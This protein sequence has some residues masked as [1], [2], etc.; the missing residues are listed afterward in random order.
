VQPV[1][2]SLALLWYV[3]FVLSTTA[4]EASH[5]LAALLGGDPT[6]YHGGQVSL[7]PVPHM[8]REPFGMVILPL[9]FAVSSGWCVGWASTPY[10]PRWEARFPRRAAWMAAAGPAANLAIAA[11]ALILL[12]AGLASGM[13]YAPDSVSLSQ[14]VAGAT[15]AVHALGAFLSILLFLNT[16]LFLF[17]LIPFPPLDGASVVG[18]LL[19]DDLALRLKETLR[20]GPLALFGLPGAWYLFGNAVSVHPDRIYG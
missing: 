7:N 3:S 13:F 15:P 6:A 19:P 8:R 4:H 18:L 12:R 11:L 9:L 17:N 2:L 5:A 10:D 20:S 16:I 1:D 14:M